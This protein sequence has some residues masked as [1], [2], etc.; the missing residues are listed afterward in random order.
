[1]SPLEIDIDNFVD[2]M[3]ALVGFVVGTGWVAVV[4]AQHY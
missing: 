4:V 2:L 3:A 1:M